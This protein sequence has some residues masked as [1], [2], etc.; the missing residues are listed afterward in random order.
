MSKSEQKK[1]IL[2]T[3]AS[4]DAEA[5]IRDL[6]A[7]KVSILHLPLEKYVVVN[8][9]KIGKKMA[10]NMESIENIVYGNKRNAKF[11]L[12]QASEHDFVQGIKNCVNLAADKLTAEYL[13]D[14]GIPAIFPGSEKPIELLEFMLRLRRIGPILYPRGSHKTEEI[15]GLLQELD[16]PVSEEILYHL[17][18][19]SR[20]ELASYRSR[21]LENK[22]NLVIYHSRRSLNRIRTAFPD[23]DLEDAVVIAGDQAVSDKLGEFEVSA[24]FVAEGTWDSIFEKVK[25]AI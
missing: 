23:L 9:D 5:I 10:A 16:I 3:A 4:E 11:F 14:R 20:Q 21:L 7:I 13:E 15:P 6:S 17:E 2:L 1:R 12:H 8:D 24:D 18:G 19:P 25:A 22:P